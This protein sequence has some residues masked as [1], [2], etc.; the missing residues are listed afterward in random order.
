MTYLSCNQHDNDPLEILAMG[1]RQ[2]IFQD[3]EKIGNDIESFGEKRHSLIHL[4]V[5]S[6]SLVYR[7]ELWFCPHQFW[8]IEDGSLQMDVDAQD[9]QLA[10]L[11]IDLLSREIHTSGQ[12]DL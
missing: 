2:L 4:Q 1:M 6:N 8:R 5:A 11:H 10:D 9:E 3:L 7:I 12:C